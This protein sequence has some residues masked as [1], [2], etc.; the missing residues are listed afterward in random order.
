MKP[1]ILTETLSAVA[2]TLLLGAAQTHATQTVRE[3]FDNLPN[4]VVADGTALDGMTNDVTTVGLEGYWTNNPTGSTGIGYKG[5]WTVNWVMEG[6]QG[7][8]LPDQ[9]EINGQNGCLDQY[10]GNLDT[11][12]DPN[13]GNPYGEWSSQVYSTHP[14]APSAQV[15]FKAAGTYW[16]SVRIEKNYS[17]NAGDSSA[18]LGL[19]TGNGTNDHFIGFGVTRPAA[20]AADGSTD[21]GDTDYV[22]FGTLGQAGFPG[23][24]DTGGPYLPHATGPAQL[25]NSGAGA[26][27]WAESGLVVGRLV[28]TPSGASELDVVT[29]LPNASL[30]TFTLDPASIVWDATTTFTETNLMTQLLVWMHGNNVEYDAIRIGTTYADVVGLEVQGAPVASPSSTVYAGTT[31]TLTSGAQVDSGNTPMSYQWLSNGVLVAGATSST[32][33]LSNT[34]TA[35]TANYSVIVTN[36]F[37]M[38][39]S[40]PVHLVFNPLTPAF[41]TSKPAPL[42]RY[43]GSPNATFT[44]AV[45]GTPPYTYQ[46]KFGG[47]NLGSP[48]TTSAQTN[49]L[50]LSTPVTASEANTYSVTVSNPGGSTNSGDVTFTVIVPPAGS[51]AAALSAL[52]PWG[53][54]RLDDNV[55]AGGTTNPVIADQWGGNDGAAINFDTPQFDVPAAPFV[56]FPTPHNGIYIGGDANSDPCKINLPKLPVWTNTMTFTMWVSNGAA[57]FVDHA[58]GYG[59][60]YGLWNNSGELIFEWEGLANGWD[61][62]L[63]LPSGTGWSFV[64]L[65][66]QPDQATVYLGTNMYSMVS[67]GSGPGSFTLSDSDSVGDT[68][69]MYPFGL[70]RNEWPFSE[71]GKGNS[72]NTLGGNW[73]DVSIFYQSLTGQQVTN[74]FLAGVGS[75]ITGQPDGTG[76]L[77]LNWVPGGTLQQASIVTGPYT[78]IG[79]AT[80]PYSAPLLST[81][82]KFYRVKR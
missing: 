78:D 35:F 27:N 80:P 6:L 72:W 68:A 50:V 69:S 31:V 29:I 56:G 17:W 22:T 47:N 45:D 16:F 44:C 2:L 66:V 61:T 65:V 30:A 53:Y 7:N 21:I 38:L 15:N 46:W 33:T 74:L 1:R 25:F 77:V 14:L 41:F 48:T 39:T 75:W 81:G 82:M 58:N 67:S 24:D 36:F 4:A 49:T 70:A 43:V 32:Y 60:Q 63:Q 37:G 26:V 55:L 20:T 13:T 23:Q 52:Q 12:V 34:T 54:W 73:S 19:S 10:L 28:T 57:Q 11:L 18:G 51:Y 42:T 8:I 9:A 59:N 62:G 40:P 76:N 5:S 71:D 3:L 79:A 64:A